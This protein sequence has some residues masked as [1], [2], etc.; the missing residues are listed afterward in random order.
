M[1]SFA[2]LLSTA[3]LVALAQAHGVLLNA[4]GDA[5]S[6]ASIGFQVSLDIARNCTSI[7]PCQQDT[8]IIRDQEIKNNVVNECGR[9]ELTGNIDIGENTENALAA[10]QVTQ[11]KAG[12][13]VQVTIHQVN[14]DGAGPYA[15][16]L[17]EA[18]N[19]GVISQ[20]LTVLDNVPGVNGFSQ[21]RTQDFNITVVMPDKFNC[22]GSSAGN[23][24]T[25]RCRN[26]AQAGPFGGCFPVQQTDNTPSANTAA[27]VD[28]AIGVEAVAK[29]VADDQA[30]FEAAVAANVVAGSKEGL[31]NLKKVEDILNAK[32]STLVS[33][34]A[35]VQ[36]LSVQL[37]GNAATVI[38]SA[39]S[40]AAAQPTRAAGGNGQGNGQGRGQG[41]GG[42]N[43]GQ[44]NGRNNA[45]GFSQR[46]RVADAELRGA[47]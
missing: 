17:I 13:K 5:G 27:T 14:A 28:T 24:C 2:S 20:N 18:G 41:R 22:V 43:N 3:A 34:A 4:Q 47:Y 31:A 23:V 37:G 19:N 1:P 45:R 8:T 42:Q 9:T 44:G 40:A 21:A 26:N 29:Q 39:T 35:P 38:A 30:D 46:R 36:T 15:C 6:P 10:K 25:V 16:D 33:L 12:S 11:V 7:N 32:T